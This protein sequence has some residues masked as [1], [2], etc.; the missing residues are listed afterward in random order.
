MVVLG[1][2]TAPQLVNDPSETASKTTKVAASKN[3]G[4]HI[5]YNS[6][7]LRYKRYTDSLSAGK[8]LFS[9]MNFN[10]YVTESLNGDIH[11]VFENWASGGPEVGWVRSTDGGATFSSTVNLSASGGN[12]KHPHI[13]PFGMGSSSEALM[14]YYRANSKLLYYSRFNGTSWS[15]EASIG[16]TSESEYDCVGMAWSQFNGSVWRTFSPSMTSSRMRNYTGSWS[17]EITLPFASWVVRQRLA[18]NASGQVMILWDN[19]G[20]IF[21]VLYAPD[22]GFGPVL[23]LGEVGYGGAFDVCAVPGTNDFYM[24][25][26]KGANRIVGRRWNNGQWLTEELI[27]G[28][29][30]HALTLS[31][32]VAC[33]P[34]GRLICAWEYWGSGNAQQHYSIRPA[35]PLINTVP[36]LFSRTVW[37]GDNLSGDSFILSNAGAGTMNYTISDNAGWLSTSVTSGSLN[38]GQNTSVN[39]DYVTDSLTAGTWNGAITILAPGAFNTPQVIPVTVEIKTVKP[40]FDGDG[41]VDQEDFGY[42]QEC[43]S[44][45][46]VPQENPACQRAMLDQDND[47]DMDDLT[48][49]MDCLSGSDVPADP[50]CGR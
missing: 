16:S 20:S 31:P 15:A 12:A 44:G 21:Y 9:P 46:F 2:W 23:N 32:S 40:D 45:P 48:V 4:F 35:G 17:P 43:Y 10:H 7:V 5:V 14:S 8:T 22:S 18:V 33:D 42:L 41:D 28:S 47:V 30:P 34:S 38:S 29:L 27:S 11:V 3:G 36:T 6:G 24:V 37:V 49:F 39:I 13:V 25:W 50:D 19:E 26:G 1:Q